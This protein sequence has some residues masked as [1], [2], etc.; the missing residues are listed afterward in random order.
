MLIVQVNSFTQVGMLLF[1]SKNLFTYKSNNS[2]DVNLYECCDKDKYAYDRVETQ[3]AS[4]FDSD[5]KFDRDILAY[6]FKK[7]LKRK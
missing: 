1:T 7:A 6:A 3:L 5:S 4:T 2:V